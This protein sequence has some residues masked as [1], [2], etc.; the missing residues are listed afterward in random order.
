M[1]PWKNRALSSRLVEVRVFS[2][3][4][5]GSYFIVLLPLLD[6]D[7]DET[8]VDAGAL[9]RGSGERI[10]FVDDE[11][12]MASMGKIILERIGYRTDSETT[13]EAALQAFESDP[14]R[15]DL[16]ITDMTMPNMTGDELAGLRAAAEAVQAV[17]L[18]PHVLDPDRWLFWLG[19]IFILLVYFFTTIGINASLKDLLKGGM[20]LVILLAITIAYMFLQNLTGISVEGSTSF[21]MLTA[22]RMISSPT[23]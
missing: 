14:G 9:M 5:K 23:A 12:A 6:P 19:I 13:P 10:L 2:R 1:S 20:P 3:V 15:Y 8:Q 4:G 22:L 11:P 17:P 21:M 18:L 16:M 7:G